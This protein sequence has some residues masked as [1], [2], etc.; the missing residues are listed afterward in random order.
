VGWVALELGLSEMSSKSQQRTGTNETLVLGQV[1]LEA[2]EMGGV[3]GLI[4]NASEG[5]YFR[6]LSWRLTLPTRGYY[7]C[8]AF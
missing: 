3:T 4:D 6:F 1:C 2:D 5:F 7:V 8:D